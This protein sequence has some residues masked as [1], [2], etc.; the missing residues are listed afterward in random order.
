MFRGE[1]KL[2]NMKAN[3]MVWVVGI[4]VAGLIVAAFGTGMF[5]LPARPGSGSGT[6]TQLPGATA[7]TPFSS[8]VSSWEFTAQDSAAQDDADDVDVVVMEWDETK[9]AD[10]VSKGYLDCSGATPVLFDGDNREVD[11]AEENLCA[12]NIYKGLNDA[13]WTGGTIENVLDDYLK[14]KQADM[15]VED[16][17]DGA[18]ETVVL[19]TSKVYLVV[20]SEVA[21]TDDED[22][23]P[24]AFLLAADGTTNLDATSYEDGSITVFFNYQYFSE[25]GAH[26]KLQISGE[27]N[28]DEDNSGINLGAS[29]DGAIHTSLTTGTTITLDCEVYVEVTEDG[30]AFPLVNDLATSTS[31]E[32]YIVFGPYGENT[33]QG[34]WIEYGSTG[35]TGDVAY[36]SAN[37]DTAQILWQGSSA[38][39]VTLTDSSSTD[40]VKGG[41]ENLYESLNTCF[42]A[43]SENYGNGAIVGLVD[44]GATL[45]IPVKIVEVMVDYDLATAANDEI[46]SAAEGSS[47]ESFFDIDLIGLESSTDRLAQTLSG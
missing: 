34:S 38:C 9:N 29:L 42:A 14:V 4:I 37:G 32:A 36:S 11:I 39:G 1:T 5:T 33:T 6:G 27:C 46:V 41:A 31:E 23:I 24:F 20:V 18:D 15:A 47:A 40:A 13:S 17:D 2:I 12:I 35:L 7:G 10:L 45:T 43:S 21:T 44:D 25:A 19:S 28:D 26:S 30:Y 8:Y 22:V 16:A 3:T